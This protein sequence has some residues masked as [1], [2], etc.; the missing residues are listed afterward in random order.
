MVMSIDENMIPEFVQ[1]MAEI[2][3]STHG[4]EISRKRIRASGKHNAMIPIARLNVL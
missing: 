3:V 1:Y 2:D 4:P